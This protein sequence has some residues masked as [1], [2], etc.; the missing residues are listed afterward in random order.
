MPDAT[1]GNQGYSQLV[2]LLGNFH[3]NSPTAEM[4]DTLER[5]LAWLAVRYGLNT[6]VGATATFVSRGSNKWPAQSEVTGRVI[7]GHRDM[8][9]TVCPGD[10]VYPLLETEIPERVNA[11]V[12]ADAPTTAGTVPVVSLPVNEAASAP[13]PSTEVADSPTSSATNDLPESVPPESDAASTVATSP[14]G[15]AANSSAPSTGPN[16]TTTAPRAASQPPPAQDRGRN[17]VPVIAVVAAGSAALGAAA[18]VAALRV[19][20]NTDEPSADATRSGDPG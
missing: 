14:E 2:C 12:R 8:S 17:D 19:K 3:E 7:S 4:L 15:T 18:L 16:A 13:P 9:L 1:G 20:H 11:L 5:L 6:E 10:F